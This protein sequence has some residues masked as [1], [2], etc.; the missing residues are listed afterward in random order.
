[1]V[2]ACKWTYILVSWTMTITGA[3]NDTAVRRLDERNKGVV[4]KSCLP[5]TDCISEMSN[6][7]ID[8]LK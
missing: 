7:Q 1:M 4:F 6:A 3:G 8:N 5:F 2:K